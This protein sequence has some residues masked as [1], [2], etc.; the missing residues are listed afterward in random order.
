MSS[1]LPRRGIRPDRVRY[2]RTRRRAVRTSPALSSWRDRAIVTGIVGVL[3]V[4]ACCLPALDVSRGLDPTYRISGFQAITTI[5]AQLTVPWWANVL[6]L[7]GWLYLLIRRYRVAAWFSW[8]AAVV[9]SLLWPPAYVD[10]LQFLVGAF[11]VD[12]IH[13]G[14]YVWLLTCVV[15]VSCATWLHLFE[16]E[17]VRQVE[18]L[19]E[20]AELCGD[21]QLGSLPAPLPHITDPEDRDGTQAL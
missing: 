2:E 9:A 14:A 20:K 12:E 11:D 4:T 16:R 13:S 6:L 7:F 10:G 5:G 3:Y 15:L 19:L 1:Q 17:R 8:S 21:V 18:S